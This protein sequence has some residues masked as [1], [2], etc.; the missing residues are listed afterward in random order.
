MTSQGVEG[1]FTGADTGLLNRYF[2]E[3]YLEHG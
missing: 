1:D 2:R 3:Y